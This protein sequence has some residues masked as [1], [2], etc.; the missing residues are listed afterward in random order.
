MHSIIRVATEAAREAGAFLH[1]NFKADLTVETKED[2]SLVTNVDHGAEEIIVRRIEEAFPGHD[3]LGEERGRTSR[4]S[5]HLWA[6]DPMDGTHNYIRGMRDYGVSIGVL[7]GNAFVAGVIY[8]P[9]TD[10]LYAAERGSGAYL[11]GKKIHV[12]TRRDLA[13]CMMGFDS[14]LRSDITRKLH[15]LEKLCP[16]IFNIR[17]TGSAA[18]S[19][20][21]IGEGVLDGV[22]EFSEKLWD[23]AAGV[24][25]VQEAGGS[26]T[27]HD[28]GLLTAQDTA[29]V[30][31]NGLIHESLCQ[32]ARS[33]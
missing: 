31:S 3:I 8:I 25:I 29:W 12:S 13:S 17:M 23:F 10:E 21:H 22:I 15:A 27:R 24:V 33:A 30:A 20:S 5:N 16:R 32:I 4:N 2:R 11:N 28:G 19:L 1:A 26:A 18:R 9:E 6:I 14:E 7:V